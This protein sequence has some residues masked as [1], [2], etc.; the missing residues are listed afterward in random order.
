MREIIENFDQQTIFIK[1]QEVDRMLKTK[2][3][4]NIEHKKIA[5]V[6]ATHNRLSYLLTYMYSV[7]LQKKISIKF[8][9]SDDSSTDQTP[10]YFKELQKKYPEIIFY[11]Y[12]IYNMGPSNNRKIALEY[13]EEDIIIFADDDD[14]YVNENFLSEGYHCLNN[15][16]NNT[17]IY[18]G[19]ASVLDVVEK[20]ETAVILNY[21][22]S[23]TKDVFKNLL[24]SM[25][26][27][28][29]TFLLIFKLTKN[30]KLKLS[31]MSMLN[32]V[33]IYLLVLDNFTD[34]VT[35]TK[36]VCGVYREHASNITKTLNFD[37]M[38]ANFSQKISI[39]NGSIL[40]NNEKNIL[41]KKHIKVTTD[42]YLLNSL[43][44]REERD[45]LFTT[46][47][48]FGYPISLWEQWKY[49]RKC[50]KN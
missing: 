30:L 37:F 6:L 49:H 5:I 11:N 46:L 47:K 19:S 45:K 25:R 7:L 41:I 23:S 18:F 43:T 12:S 26:K 4:G 28:P 10:E 36:D 20:S 24:F 9:I 13:V 22:G 16:K 33:S 15:D 21:L 1:M 48:N 34:N 29:S 31:N 2:V 44:T 50:K 38:L 42:Y 17:S 14:Y 8:Y 39:I 32:D 40:N 35:G 27:P 3:S